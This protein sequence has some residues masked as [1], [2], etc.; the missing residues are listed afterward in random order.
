MVAIE[1]DAVCVW[2]RCIYSVCSVAAYT[3]LY[4][5]GHIENKGTQATLF[6][7]TKCIH[8]YSRSDVNYTYHLDGKEMLQSL[9]TKVD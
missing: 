3:K 7:L 8:N 4:L 2:L 9:G 6:T 1:S 5:H